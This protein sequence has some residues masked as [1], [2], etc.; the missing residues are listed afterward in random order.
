MK[1]AV[2]MVLA[3]VT[4]SGANGDLMDR[5]DKA[6]ATKKM[7][8]VKK[9]RDLQD[10]IGGHDHVHPHG[11]CDCLDECICTFE[12]YQQSDPVCCRSDSMNQF[13]PFRNMCTAYLTV[14]DMDVCDHCVPGLCD[15][16]HPE[17][18]DCPVDWDPWCCGGK[19]YK[20][21]CDAMCHDIDVMAADPGCE[22]DQ[23]PIP[24]N[25]DSLDNDCDGVMVYTVV[26]TDSSTADWGKDTAVCCPNPNVGETGYDNMCLAVYAGNDG[27]ECREKLSGG[28]SNS[29]SQDPR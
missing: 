2:T 22:H 3:A 20:S 13:V 4:I 8:A 10:L 9:Q 25:D 12:S 11:M 21:R 28:C 26:Y 23:C 19:T 14:M 27:T 16:V 7:S 6:M 17:T 24:A 15:R 18:C 1:V 5:L 29:S